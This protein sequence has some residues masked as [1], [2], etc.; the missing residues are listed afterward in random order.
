MITEYTIL[1]DVNITRLQEKVTYYLVNGWQ[2]LGGVSTA[3]VK[4]NAQLM[5]QNQDGE[6]PHYTQTMVRVD[7]M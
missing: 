4:L 6:Q 2:Q 7:L 5:L 3:N 1:Q